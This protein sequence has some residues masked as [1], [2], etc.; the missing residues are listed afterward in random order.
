MQLHLLLEE[1][2]RMENIHVSC[3]AA[4]HTVGMW[5]DGGRFPSPA[6]RC[7]FG[8]DCALRC[9]PAVLRSAACA[10]VCA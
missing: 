10:Q 1:N 4:W 5:W 7:G 2:G 9:A 8:H 3:A 6:Q